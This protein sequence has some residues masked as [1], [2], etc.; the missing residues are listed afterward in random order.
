[1]PYIYSLSGM[2]TQNDY[3]IMRALVMDFGNDENVLNIG[4]QF[5]FGPALLVNPVTQYKART[6]EVYLPAGVGW[7]DLKTGR[8]YQG[9]QTI[10]AEAPYSNIPVFVKAGSIIPFGPEIEYSDEKPADPLRVY[11]YTG[12]NGAFDLYED[13]N[14][15]YN[16]EKGKFAV[17]PFVYNEANRTCTIGERTGE[18]PGMLAQRTIEIVWVDKEKGAGLDFSRKADEIVKYNGSKVTLK[19]K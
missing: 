17:I 4:D 15:N 19:K 16:Y 2:V 18:F 10:Q 8:F 12:Q 13:E 6:R 11:V 7:Y 5:M 14:V 3:T 1:M 9:G